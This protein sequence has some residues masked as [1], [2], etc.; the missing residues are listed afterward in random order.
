[1]PPLSLAAGSWRFS[2]SACKPGRPIASRGRFSADSPTTS[3]YTHFD[4]ALIFMLSVLLQIDL[5]SILELLQIACF[6]WSNFG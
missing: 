6:R 5:L 3:N 1:M 2:L 4:A